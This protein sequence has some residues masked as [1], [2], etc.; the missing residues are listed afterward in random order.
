MAIIVEIAN[1]MLVYCGRPSEDSL[2]YS[3]QLVFIYGRLD[4]YRV[5]LAIE[6]RNFLSDKAVID[7]VP[8]QDEYNITSLIPNFGKEVYIETEDPSIPNFARRSIPVAYLQDANRISQ[9]IQNPT[10][11]G[12]ALQGKHSAQAMTFWGME[13][14]QIMMR[15]I[16]VPILPCQYRIWYENTRIPDPLDNDPLPFLPEFHDLI[17]LSSAQ[18]AL[19]NCQ[20]FTQK[21]HPN[22]TEERRLEENDKKFAK[23]SQV[24]T[25]R[26]AE[27]T[28]T[29]KKYKQTNHNERSGLRP[30]FSSRRSNRRRSSIWGNYGY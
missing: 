12:P 22:L 5:E 27:L 4:H 8:Y 3:D 30:G 6:N 14:G 20:W 23:L 24:I 15:V 13:S 17:A 29:F 26:L 21:S 1:K 19:P 7:I 9:D 18:L 2:S 11:F 16:P 10:G 28:Q 25:P